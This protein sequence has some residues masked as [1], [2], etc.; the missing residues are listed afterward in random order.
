[1]RLLLTPVVT[2][3]SNKMQQAYEVA[4]DIEAATD[5]ASIRVPKFFQYDGASI[6]GIAWQLVGTPFNPRFMLAAVFH[7]WLYH[8]HQL[9]RRPADQ[10]FRQL[11][12]DSQVDEGT[13]E[14]MY[15]AVRLAGSGYWKN[16][17]DD[18]DYLDRLA[19]RIVGDGRDPARYGLPG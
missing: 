10:L 5:G 11:L 2:P 19:S 17:A 3:D 15:R 7:D 9:E 6:P 18:Q 8:T 1:M 14:A 12:L 16:D 4:E 13:A